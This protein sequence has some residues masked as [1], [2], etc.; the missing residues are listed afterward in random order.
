MATK[1]NKP[2]EMTEEERYN[3]YHGLD[4][5]DKEKKKLKKFA[6]RSGGFDW[7]KRLN[8][9]NRE[10]YLKSRQG[11]KYEAM[12]RAGEKRAE[13][14][15]IRYNKM[16]DPDWKPSDDT[17]TGRQK[18]LDNM[19]KRNTALDPKNDPEMLSTLRNK[20][21]INPTNAEVERRLRARSNAKLQ[22]EKLSEGESEGAIAGQ[23]AEAL[24][25]L[26]AKELASSRTPQAYDDH[27]IKSKE[28]YDKLTSSDLEREEGTEKALRDA[29]LTDRETG[30]FK[31]YKR[32]D[33]PEEE[34]GMMAGALRKGGEGLDAIK[35]YFS[36]ATAHKEGAEAAY[37]DHMGMGVDRR[38]QEA[39]D[40]KKAPWAKLREDEIAKEEADALINQETTLDSTEMDSEALD[41]WQQDKGSDVTA[42]LDAME[43]LGPDKIEQKGAIDQSEPKPPTTQEEAQQAIYD[44][45][46]EEQKEIS[47]LVAEQ[48]GMGSDEWVETKEATGKYVRYEGT[49]L[50]INMAMLQKDIDR[51]R[52][53]EMLKHIPAANRPAMLVEWGYIDPDDLSVAQKKSAKEL[54]D[55][56][57]VNLKIAETKLKMENMKGSV[58]KKD[59]AR[60]NAALKGFNQALKDKDYGLAEVHRN[61]LNS[62]MPTGDTSNYTKL[63]EDGIK[64]AKIKTPKKVFAAY[65]VKASDYIKSKQSIIEKVNF[66]KESKGTASKEFDLWQGQ[67]TIDRG[68][69]KGTTYERFFQTQ[70]IFSWDKVDPSKNEK[71]PE[72]A[73][74]PSHA[75]KSEEAYFGWALPEIEKKLMVGI[76]GNLHNEVSAIND[77]RYEEVKKDLADEVIRMPQP[78]EIGKP[79]PGMIDLNKKAANLK[80][81]AP[82]V[83][84]SSAEIETKDI[85]LEEQKKILKEANVSSNIQNH[86][87]FK[88]GEKLGE[89]VQWVG[90]GFV[91]VG[92]FIYNLFSEEGQEELQKK[93]DSLG[94]E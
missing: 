26:R 22:R 17:W 14:E 42:K 74:V 79:D 67:N 4:R 15:R 90:R 36:G 2:H 48:K 61:E 16:V 82:A 77:R 10:S 44:V 64:K 63:I 33:E 27:R 55:L 81:D 59:E 29:Y 62:I 41:D 40:K 43:A 24:R 47:K 9:L 89:G 87:M 13:A 38:L 35:D 12:S 52:N 56:E 1:S 70:G 73:K 20:L 19:R 54:K 72:G 69:H 86:V 92:N 5:S 28:R 80:K 91:K 51:N 37:A 65:G 32:V 85:S 68:E 50:V 88:A 6:E 66:L 76:W 11:D 84:Q 3:W 60:Y 45:S 75:L 23:K 93:L 83:Q 7:K 71:L 18:I 94:K 57:L 8:D 49:G 58:P 21:N 31:D 78:W 39:A 30:Q 34:E 46:E 53:M 25:R